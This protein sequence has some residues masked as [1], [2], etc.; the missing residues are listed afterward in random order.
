[1]RIKLKLLKGKELA[2]LQ[3]L[4]ESAEVT[5]HYIR[6]EISPKKNSKYK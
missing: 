4:P 1:M 2:A 3:N 6:L 5:T